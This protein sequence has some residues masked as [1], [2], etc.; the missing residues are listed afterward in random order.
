MKERC[1]LCETTVTYGLIYYIAG[2]DARCCYDCLPEYERKAFDE[3]FGGR[4]KEQKRD[5]SMTERTDA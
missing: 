4:P 1:P 5:P 2:S 3:V